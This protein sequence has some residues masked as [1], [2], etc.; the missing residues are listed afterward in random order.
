MWYVGFWSSI[1]QCKFCYYSTVT[2]SLFCYAFYYLKLYAAI[3]TSKEAH[4]FF[5]AIAKTKLFLMWCGAAFKLCCT[6]ITKVGEKKT[7]N[8]KAFA[9]RCFIIIILPNNLLFDGKQNEKKLNQLLKAIQHMHTSV[10]IHKKLQKVVTLVQWGNKSRNTI[11]IAFHTKVKRL[12]AER[13]FLM[14]IT[15]LPTIRWNS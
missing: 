1:M 4:F 14:T 13:S 7:A 3:K 5:F 9:F 11:Q 2:I 6:T 15:T 8:K 12:R 10:H